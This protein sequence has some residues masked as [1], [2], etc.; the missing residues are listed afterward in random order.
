MVLTDNPDFT[1]SPFVPRGTSSRCSMIKCLIHD[2]QTKVNF[3]SSSIPSPFPS[4]K[5]SLPGA[6]QRCL[7]PTWRCSPAPPARILFYFPL[8]T[9][10]CSLRLEQ[11]LFSLIAGESSMCCSILIGPAF[12]SASNVYHVTRY[13]HF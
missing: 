11:N 5:E 8:R 4:Q 6:K 13:L 1:Y 7:P 9:F 2:T 12:I 10:R 3:P